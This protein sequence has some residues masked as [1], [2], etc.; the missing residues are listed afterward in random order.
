MAGASNVRTNAGISASGISGGTTTLGAG[1]AN[2]VLIQLTG[3]QNNL[4]DPAAATPAAYAIA[5]VIGAQAVPASC[6]FK[7]VEVP[8]TSI[9]GAATLTGWLFRDANKTR[10]FAGPV[11]ATLFDSGGTGGAILKFDDEYQCTNTGVEELGSVW[12]GL[13]LNA[14][15]ADAIKPFANWHR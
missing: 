1:V 5:N 12:V 3:L 13:F 2:I 4:D 14:G 10:P 15:S 11:S 6:T 9:S 7:E 8:M